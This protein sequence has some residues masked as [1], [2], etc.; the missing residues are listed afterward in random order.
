MEWLGNNPKSIGIHRVSSSRQKDNTSHGVQGHE[1]DEYCKFNGLCL[2]RVF[3]IV[4]SAKDSDL[5]KKYHAAIKWALDNDIRHIIFYMFDRE[6]R[7]LTDNEEN[8][9]LVRRDRIVLHY[10]RERK[11]LHKWSP[12]S[13]FL[14]RDFHAIQNK[15]YSRTLSAKVGDSMRRK[16]EEG[17]YPANIPPLGYVPQATH[18]EEGKER[19][20]GKV[21]GLDPILKNRQTVLREYE[22]RARGLS[23]EEI[24]KKIIDEG[25]CPTRTSLTYH[26]SV[27][28]SRIK[29]PF[30]RGRFRWEGKE[31]QGKHELFISKNILDAVDRTLYKRHY[32]LKPVTNDNALG[33]GW[34]TCALPGCGCSIGY[35]PKVKKYRNGAEQVFHYHHCTNGRRAHKSMKG[36]N[37]TSEKLWEQL[38]TALDAISVTADFVKELTDAMNEAQRK[39][40]KA[41]IVE[42]DNFKAAIEITHKR[43]DELYADYKTGLVTESFYIRQVEQVRQE[44]LRFTDQLKRA[45]LSIS[46]AGMETAK[47]ILELCTSAKSLWEKRTPLERR[48]FLNE[49]LSNPVL[50]GPTVRYELKKPF[51]ILSE[52]KESEKWRTRKGS[53]L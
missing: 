3:E 35:D 31:Y 37:I 20:R 21:V 51:R 16:A 46:N 34:I 7:N 42:M 17:W 8:E 26:A 53:N 15:Q 23:F 27:V 18:N 49:I 38:E 10:V 14:M 36:M 50:D 52:M 47:T 24:R 25:L 41:T 11:V 6:A 2:E 40:Q 22:L 1:T 33:G 48:E 30:Y 12:D 4:E 9:K 32:A 43:E 13:D 28:E 45:Q 19:R 5:R 39:T 29:N 44:R